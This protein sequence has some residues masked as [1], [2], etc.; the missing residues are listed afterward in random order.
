[1]KSYLHHYEYD[2]NP[3]GIKKINQLIND[4]KALYNIRSDMR[5]DKFR[6]HPDLK[7]LELNKL[8]KYVYN[9]KNK[10]L[11]WIEK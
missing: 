3:L 1:M 6:N 2:N 4:R 10:F 9:N 5:L 7:L 11:D 8:P